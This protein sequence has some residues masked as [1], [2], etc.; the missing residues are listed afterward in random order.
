[1][2]VAGAAH[3]EQRRPLSLFIRYHRP[4]P[5]RDAVA[6]RIEAERRGRG[7]DVLRGEIGDA[8]RPLASFSLAFA[9]DA[10][11][12][13]PLRSQDV[14]PMAPLSA[15]QPVWQLVAERGGE[16]ATV[17]RRVGFL[18]ERADVARSDDGWH[19]SSAWPATP[20]DD[21]VIRAAVTIM[22]IDWF[23]AP[24]T[25]RANRLD[26]NEPWPVNMPSLDLTAWFYAPETAAPDGWLPTRTA[27]PVSH[28]GFSV[29]RTQVFAGTT[30][31][32]EG[33]SQA[34]L[35]PAAR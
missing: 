13:G 7:V 18:G 17:M 25:M 12:G 35:L 9:R 30:L 3:T 27:V 20:S 33:M 5:I 8:A 34:M 2:L 14:P 29:G 21:V 15:P 11:D 10:P 26:L 22:P 28:A 16:P 4:V 6:L 1:M 23:V 19:L 24:A 32:A 31:V